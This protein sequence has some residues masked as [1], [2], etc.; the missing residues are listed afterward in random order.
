[1]LII[2]LGKRIVN[3]YYIQ[4]CH[5]LNIIYFGINSININ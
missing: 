5:R 1:M 3:K 2:I 4:N